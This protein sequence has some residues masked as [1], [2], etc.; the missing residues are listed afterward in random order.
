MA[1]RLFREKGYPYTSLDDITREIGITKPAVYYYF[2]AK[3]DIL[4]EICLTA[5]NNLMNQAKA[6]AATDFDI[7]SKVRKMFE[8]HILQF[9]INRDVAESYWRE[10]AHLS[11]ERRKQVS[12]MLK[13]YESFIRGHIDQGIAE[14]VFRPIDTKQIARGIGGMCFTV[15][16]WYDPAGKEHIS[17]IADAYVDFIMH[18]LMV[19][20]EN[21]CNEQPGG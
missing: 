16:N 7:V 17:D 12:S 8:N 2:K 10:A 13:G 4:Y 6:V 9:H 3:E 5:I 19:N 1:A 14:G 18:G 20:K 11:L 21:G 15:G